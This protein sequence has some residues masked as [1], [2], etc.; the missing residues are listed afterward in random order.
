METSD[1][2]QLSLLVQGRLL[3]LHRLGKRGPARG[4]L[5]QQ[6][7]TLLSPCQRADSTGLNTYMPTLHS[8]G[9][10]LS[11]GLARRPAN[12][13]QQDQASRA[14]NFSSQFKLSS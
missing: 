9:P 11:I 5:G 12:H 13:H 4:G 7:C 2:T 3:N 6:L 10:S 1:P 14:A 8:H